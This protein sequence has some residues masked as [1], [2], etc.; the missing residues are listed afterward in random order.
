MGAPGPGPF[1]RPGFPVFWNPSA[2]ADQSFQPPFG[3]SRS[4]SFWAPPPPSGPPPPG[5]GDCSDGRPCC[6]DSK[7]VLFPSGVPA[8]VIHVSITGLT[9]NEQATCFGY[10]GNFELD[11]NFDGFISET[12]CPEFVASIG[13]DLFPSATCLC[14]SMSFS[15][16]IFRSGSEKCGDY[17]GDYLGLF[18][19]TPIITYST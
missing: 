16:F 7:G 19:G 3:Q 9:P 13:G 2:P 11:L 18:T 6:G 17:S 1:P 14:G 4:P 5:P 8:S 15:M 12:G 10:D